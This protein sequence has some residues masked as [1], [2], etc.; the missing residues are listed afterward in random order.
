MTNKTGIVKTIYP[1]RST[2][3]V[4][5]TDTGLVSAELQIGYRGSHKDKDYWMPAIDEQVMVHFT[6]QGVGYIGY[7]IPSEE[8]QPPVQDKNKRHLAFEDG[9]IIEYDKG[10]HTLLIDCKGPINIIATSNVIVTGDVIA[11]GISLKNH[12]HSCPDG[13]TSAPIGGD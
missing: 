8:D 9:T 7:S 3:R 11:D 1:D 6:E 10:T 5:F 2:A 12:T 13:I 4:E